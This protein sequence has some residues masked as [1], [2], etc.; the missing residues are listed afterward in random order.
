[1]ADGFKISNQA[2]TALIRENGKISA[3]WIFLYLAYL[4]NSLND[5]EDCF[6]YSLEQL[7]VETNVN[8]EQ[9]LK[10]MEL[11]D[12]IGVIEFEDMKDKTFSGRNRMIKCR[13]V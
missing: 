12:T 11:L 8:R 7:S 13:I 4:N 5:N 3:R 1:M 6:Y 2:M 9:A 10:D